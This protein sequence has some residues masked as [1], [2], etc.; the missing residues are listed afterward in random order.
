[1]RSSTG[2]RRASSGASPTSGG[3][4]A[5]EHGDVEL[6]GIGKVLEHGARGD[7]RHLGDVTH[8]RRDLPGRGEG[9]GRRDD[10]FAGA[11]NAITAT[12]CCS[13]AASRA[14]S[15]VHY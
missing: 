6:G 7:T 14:G 1:M 11:G 3:Q 8:D 10:R 5:A 9:Q 12:G 2:P 15:D 4:H 13:E